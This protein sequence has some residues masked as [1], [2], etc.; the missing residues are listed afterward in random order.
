MVISAFCSFL[1][2]SSLCQSITL[3]LALLCLFFNATRVSHSP[4][5]KKT[6]LLPLFSTEQPLLSF[7]RRVPCYSYDSPT[8]PLQAKSYRDD[9]IAFA[10]LA[11]ACSQTAF[12]H[13]FDKDTGRVVKGLKRKTQ[14]LAF[15]QPLQLKRLLDAL[16]AGTAEKAGCELNEHCW[17]SAGQQE[18]SD[19]GLAYIG[20]ERVPFLSPRTSAMASGLRSKARELWSRTMSIVSA[21]LASST[22]C[23]VMM[24]RATSCESF[25]ELAVELWVQGKQDAP[26]A[27]TH[28]SKC[29]PSLLTHFIHSLPR[30]P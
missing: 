5:K 4:C 19:R 20:I 26:K 9:A 1:L 30:R 27:A 3:V 7:H 28:P 12:A 15:G 21:P 25:L 22:T 2:P 24:E 11:T 10:Q 17:I 23:R 29:I 6:L 8:I 16:R 14:A 13:H 18:C